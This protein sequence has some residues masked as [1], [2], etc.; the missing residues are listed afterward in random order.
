[1]N[2]GGFLGLVIGIALW[3]LLI[4]TVILAIKSSKDT[5]KS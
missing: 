4:A 2:F 5:D 1:M 3:V